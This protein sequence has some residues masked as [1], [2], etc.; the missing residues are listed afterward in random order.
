VDVDFDYA[1]DDVDGGVAKTHV[2]VDHD[3]DDPLSFDNVAASARGPCFRAEPLEFVPV[4]VI[5]VA[6][7]QRCVWD[8]SSDAE[9][10]AG[11][12]ALRW[13]G[14]VGHCCYVCYCCMEKGRHTRGASVYYG[15]PHP[16]RHLKR[17]RS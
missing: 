6:E 17:S 16:Y 15:A 13:M 14:C 11:S 2:L 4:P 3:D 9:G 1:H 5:S 7:L 12:I 10:G 8:L